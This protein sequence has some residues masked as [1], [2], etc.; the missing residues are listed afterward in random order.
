[1]GGSLTNRIAQAAQ[2]FL[3]RVLSSGDAAPEPT[4]WDNGVPPFPVFTG[5]VARAGLNVPVPTRRHRR[6]L[7]A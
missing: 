1:M 7:A 5:E 2:L 4:E 6:R 3:R